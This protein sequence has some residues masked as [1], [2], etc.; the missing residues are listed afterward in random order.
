MLVLSKIRVSNVGHVS[1]N[2]SQTLV[3]SYGGAAVCQGK[4]YVSGGLQQDNSPTQIVECYD[5]TIEQWVIVA[6]LPTPVY[7]HGFLPV[8]VADLSLNLSSSVG[9]SVAARPPSS[10]SRNGS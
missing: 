2:K 8:T 1:I 9:N 6:H 3:F 5:P 7:A 10:V 4:I